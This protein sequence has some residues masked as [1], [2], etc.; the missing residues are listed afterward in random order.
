M[1]EVMSI[2]GWT[3]FGCVFVISVTHTIKSCHNKEY[4]S[5]VRE[6]EIELELSKLNGENHSDKYE[7]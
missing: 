3:I 1:V 6:K 5:E 2:I 7:G 4:E